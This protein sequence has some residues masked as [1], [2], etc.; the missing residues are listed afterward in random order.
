MSKKLWLSLTHHKPQLCSQ[1]LWD[2]E[3]S[4]TCSFGSP[5]YR[6]LLF[7]IWMFHCYMKPPRQHS[8]CCFHFSATTSQLPS[9]LF[10]LPYSFLFFISSAAPWYYHLWLLLLQMLVMWRTELPWDCC[11]EESCL[12]GWPLAGIW[13]LGLVR[14]LQ[15]NT[16]KKKYVC[17]IERKRFIIRTGAHREWQVYSLQCVTAGWWSRRDDLKSRG[18]LLEDSLL[19]GRPIFCLI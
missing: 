11:P 2:K 17:I 9:T 4:F 10:F 3:V 7:P 18:S 8:V 12:Q 19:L 1:V 14:F 16:T 13:E 5:S 15:R 6:H